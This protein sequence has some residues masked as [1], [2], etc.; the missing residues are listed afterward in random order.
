MVTMT[1]DLTQ[2]K[3]MRVIIGFA[4]PLYLGMLFQ[5][6]YSLMDTV[7]VGRTLG[8][9]ALAAV[10]STGAINFLIIGFCMG[11]CS[12]FAI[13]IAQRFGAKDFS[14]MRKFVANSTWLSITFAVIM[15]VLTVT[16]CRWI[17]IVTNTPAD[18]LENA[19]RYIVVIFA[20]IP[21]IIL[22]NILSGIIRSVGDSKTPVF[23]LV[24]ASFLNI[25]LD[26]LFILGLHTG[27]EGAAYATV[28]S[29]GVSGLLCLIYMRR[30]FEILRIQKH[31]WKL[32]G[33]YCSILCGM[34][35]PMG[36]QYSITA[37]G[38]VVLQTAVNGLGSAAV[39]AIT[40]ACKIGGFLVCPFDAMGST[41]ATYGGQ[42]VGAKRL[43]RVSGGLKACSALGIGYALLALLIVYF[44]GTSLE[45]LFLD[46]SETAILAD[47]RTY[48]MLN[49]SF[50][51]PLAFVNI[52]RF[53]IQGMGFPR[54]AVFAGVAEM[55]A[56][57]LVGFILVPHFGF[58][59]AC[60]ASPVAWI[61]ADMFLFPAYVSCHKKLKRV[62]EGE[63][64][65]KTEV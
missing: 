39:A 45:Q 57:T 41:M 22:Y 13:P 3:P 51:I 62:F 65:A 4:I 43:D 33:H 42:N 18:I 61:M 27:V 1:K 64:P 28:I 2:G 56:R 60:I 50:Y 5:Q 25:G 30:R 12:G 32:D 31:E 26:F 40:A 35:V 37:I 20:G 10:G 15:T 9:H 6:F 36:L 44:F 47:A 7:I 58:I 34:G 46:A 29:Q 55:I 11:I 49:A 54:F 52:I 23:F 8:V 24:L 53:L 17:L 48:L 19:Y 21:V 38:S 16:S 14:S 59:A 63:L